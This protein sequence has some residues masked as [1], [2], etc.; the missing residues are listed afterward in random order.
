VTDQDF[1]VGVE[2]EYHLVD[3][4]TL[5]LRNA[6]V[7]V[8]SARYSLGEGAQPEIAATLLE[9]ASPVC[10]TLAEV[11][12]ALRVARTGA[13]AA[14]HKHGCRILAAGSHPAGSWQD[15]RL[16]LKPRYLELLERWGLLALQQGIAGCHVHVAVHD[17]ELRIA[18]MNRVRPYLPTLIALT[19]SSPMWEG[20]DTGYA[21]YRTQ[22]FSR[23]PTSGAPELLADRAEFDALVD[24][25]IGIGMIDDASHLYWD[26]RPSMRHPTLE[27]RVADVCPRMED[28][29]LYAALVRSLVRTAAGWAAAG[30]PPAAVRTEVLRAA[31]W[32]AARYGL[33]SDLWH[34]GSRQLRPAADVVG[35]LLAELRPDLT[36]NGEWAQVSAL[37]EDLLARGTSAD[38]Q[39]RVLADSHGDLVA[40]TAQLVAESVGAYGR[41]GV[42]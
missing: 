25:L 23:W 31:H 6:P 17:P 13:D 30:R 12:A 2:E 28:A 36:A 8:D 41:P 18:V 37:V 4:D 33:T 29:V 35:H 32:R 21:S 10:S 34:Q 19:A 24:D 7:V 26:V 5:M 39:R 22:W 14:A 38:R 20:V 15:Q 9:I 3:A 16:T 1:T 11:R 40:V 27:F 42:G